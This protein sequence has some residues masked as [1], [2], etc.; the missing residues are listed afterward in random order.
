MEAKI[1][2]AKESFM[3][4]T[5]S[6]LESTTKK[7]MHANEQ[8]ASELAFQ[9]RETERLMLRN[10]KLSEENFLVR[11][12]L[13]SY[14][15]AEQELSRR[16]HAYLKTINSLVSKLKSLEDAKQL[17]SRSSKEKEEHLNSVY[18]QRVMALQTSV[19]ETY[20]Q[21][22]QIHTNIQAKDT[23]VAPAAPPACARPC[24]AAPSHA[25]PGACHALTPADS[26]A[27]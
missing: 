12:D 3:K 2:D 21:L 27:G 8:M 14:E 5:D 18:R 24:P 26:A 1:R 11:K 23:E 10:K 25:A 22:E 17:V 19:E 4:L 6:Q 20:Q 7:T 9:N 16:N 15:Q 13:N